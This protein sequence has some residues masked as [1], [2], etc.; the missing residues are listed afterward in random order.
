MVYL[1]LEMN[2][3]MIDCNVH[4]TKNVVHISNCQYMCDKLGEWV[5]DILRKNSRIPTV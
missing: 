5:L 3:E 4:P 2:P 1:S